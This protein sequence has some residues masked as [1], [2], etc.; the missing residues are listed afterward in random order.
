MLSSSQIH[1]EHTMLKWNS[2]QW[3]NNVKAMN[4]FVQNSIC[5]GVLRYFFSRYCC[6]FYWHLV[7]EKKMNS[8]NECNTQK[9]IT[10]N[11][12]LILLRISIFC[13]FQSAAYILMFISSLN[14]KNVEYHTCRIKISKQKHAAKTKLI[15]WWMNVKL[16]EY[17]MFINY[18]EMLLFSLLSPHTLIEKRNGKCKIQ[19]L[20]NKNWYERTLYTARKAE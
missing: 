7:K 9:G 11:L 10:E 12:P 13:Q 3:T 6:C 17:I 4:W 14:M 15:E 20:N 16:H 8:M 1:S 18:N 5:V 2:R 19:L